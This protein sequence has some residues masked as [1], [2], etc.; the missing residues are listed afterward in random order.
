MPFKSPKQVHAIVEDN[1]SQRSQW[2]K[3]QENWFNIRYFGIG[4][5]VK[6]DWQSDLPFKLSDSIIARMKPQDSAH[7]WN[8]EL[9][10][11][12]T[13]KDPIANMEQT[14]LVAQDF[15]YH[16]RNK[17]NY[18]KVMNP[19]LDMRCMY[20]GAFLGFDFDYNN[21][22]L[23]FK[24]YKPTNVVLPRDTIEID[25][26]PNA[27]VI[28]YISPIDFVLDGNFSRT[29]EKY[30][31]KLIGKDKKSDTDDN[32]KDELIGFETASN[33]KIEIRRFMERT[34]TG[35]F[36]YYYSPNDM[37]NWL[38]APYEIPYEIDGRAFIP[39][40]F[41]PYDISDT[42]GVYDARGIPQLVAE[43]EAELTR[44][45]N[46]KQDSIY[47]S[48]IP[49]FKSGNLETAAPTNIVIG[50]MK[51]LPAGVEVSYFPAPN[52]NYDAAMNE[53]LSRVE[54]RVSAFDNTITDMAKNSSRRSATESEMIGAVSTQGT[55]YRYKILR[56][57]LCEAYKKCFAVL[58]HHDKS[59]SSIVINGKEI[60]IP[61]AIK[62]AKYEIEPAGTETSW[63]KERRT[64]QLMSIYQTLNA[65]PTFQ[66]NRGMLEKDILK[67]YEPRIAAKYVVDNAQLQADQRERQLSENLIMDKG[68]RL[69]ISQDD[70]N[71][72]HAITCYEDIVRSMIEGEPMSQQES[73]A[74]TEH[75]K[76]HLDAL[77]KVD[78]NAFVQ[79]QNKIAQMRATVEQ[80][81]QGAQ[82]QP[83]QQ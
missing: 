54:Q 14:V 5:E 26:A 76:A 49:Y 48:S 18:P 11:D 82:P 20:G 34:E 73:A 15:D 59:D 39:L 12:F 17:T 72:I 38:R 3:N 45:R 21:M 7:I 55:N 35:W 9:L 42:G 44:L 19:I 37:K 56:N 74:K 52:V 2:E 27:C 62:N 68:I 75:I 43:D 70:D 1:I 79:V 16:L 41:F 64:Q 4:R 8:G 47:L 60:T 36:C 66:P 33:K 28:E 65:S 53:I 31:Q 22:A 23:K 83:M 6:Y 80:A 32:S 46:L 57:S 30:L 69:P 67:S 78:S 71:A 40:V 81:M 77:K 58:R 29:D 10:A 25:D 61:L 13:S 63:S 51:A 50:T 24:A